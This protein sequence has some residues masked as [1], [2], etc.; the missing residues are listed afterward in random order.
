MTKPRST[1]LTRR[2]VLAGMGAA[3]ATVML[4][5]KVANAA[6]PAGRAVIFTNVS[7]INVPQ[8]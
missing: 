2:E 6:Q 4:D 8:N 3:A 5:S 7:V 1:D